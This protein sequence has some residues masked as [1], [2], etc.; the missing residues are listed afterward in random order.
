M[1]M[2]KIHWKAII[3]SGFYSWTTAIV[4]TPTLA[5][6]VKSNGTGA[7]RTSQRGTQE[8]AEQNS[9]SSIQ[10]KGR[11]QARSG[12][13]FDP[14]TLYLKEE[15]TLHKEEKSGSK[16]AKGHYF[17][18]S[19]VGEYFTPTLLPSENPYE[20][21]LVFHNHYL[22]ARYTFQPDWWI[23]TGIPFG[24]ATER[25]NESIVI[26]DVPLYLGFPIFGSHATSTHIRGQMRVSMPTSEASLRAAKAF[27]VRPRFDVGQ[28]L[29]GPFS[30]SYRFKGYFNEYYVEN[31]RQLLSMYT[32]YVEGGWSLTRSFS[33]LFGIEHYETYISTMD[34]ILNNFWEPGIGYNYNHKFIVAAYWLAPFESP[35]TDNSKLAMALY[36]TFL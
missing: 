2:K 34:P 35:A 27:Q 9:R 28:K 21:R 16:N 10:D 13:M 18:T 25:G 33:L 31:P 14:E 22:E 8:S 23:A 30:V 4:A 5:V 19:Y 20:S 11:D 6:D 12:A 7:L 24:N 17:S 32:H 29:G 1:D 15:S 3:I 26:G 36:W